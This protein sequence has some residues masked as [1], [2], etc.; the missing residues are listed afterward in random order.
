MN[1]KKMLLSL[2]IALIFGALSCQTVQRI[3]NQDEGI[4]NRQDTNSDSLLPT[5]PP[6]FLPTETLSDLEPTE[7]V[8]PE[9]GLVFVDDFSDRSSGWPVNYE[10]TLLI[11]YYQEGYHLALTSPD[12]ITWAVVGPNFENVRIQV[13]SR[14]IGGEE[15]NYY[16]VI[17]RYQDGNNFYAG[18][19]SSDGFSA[20]LHLKDG[21]LDLISGDSFQESVVINQHMDLNLIVFTCIGSQFQLI[22][23]GQLIAEGEDASIPTGDVGL[24]IGTLS[25]QSSD[26]LFD[27]YSLYLVEE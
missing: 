10:E 7:T 22:V 21:T 26:I 2:A 6:P 13:D 9:D 12:S 23:N 25:A 16:G 4:S 17:C 3:S 18:V 14:Q 15:D 1:Q 20:I 11:D 24:I 19:I 8:I 5:T 27:N